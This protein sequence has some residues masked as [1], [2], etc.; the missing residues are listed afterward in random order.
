[1]STVIIGVQLDAV[2]HYQRGPRQRRLSPVQS[3]DVRV[4]MSAHGNAPAL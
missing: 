2:V 1:M 4:R 3:I